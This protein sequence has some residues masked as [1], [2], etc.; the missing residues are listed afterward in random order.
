MRG[1]IIGRYKIGFDFAGNQTIGYVIDMQTQ[2][3]DSA[4]VQDV[5]FD[6]S[7]Y[8]NLQELIQEEG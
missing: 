4:V 1:H 8:D 2:Q 7:E 5:N 6:K 3:K